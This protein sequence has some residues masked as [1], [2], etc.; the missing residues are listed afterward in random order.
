[1][2]SVNKESAREEV[3]KIKSEFDRLSANKQMNDETRA[4]I[5]SMFMI[6]NLLLSIFLEKNNWIHVYSAGDITL[7]FLHRKRGSE[8]TEDINII[9]RYGGHNCWASYLSYNNCEHGLCGSHLTREL[10]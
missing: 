8:A 9:P 10:T 1:M 5:Q 2:A 6:I 3:V 4:L 7:K